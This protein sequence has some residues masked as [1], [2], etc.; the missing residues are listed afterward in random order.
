MTLT[1]RSNRDSIYIILNNKV[2]FSCVSHIQLDKRESNFTD[3]EYYH[4]R[5][6][7]MQLAYLFVVPWFAFVV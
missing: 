4:R 6:K 5:R 3:I 7:C 2:F 1:I